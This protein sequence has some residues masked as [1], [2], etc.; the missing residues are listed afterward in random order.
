MAGEAASRLRTAPELATLLLELG[1]LIRAR[2]YYAPGDQR[3]AG[4]FERSLRAWRS[5]LGRRG[6]LEIEVVPEG[7]R[8]SGGRGVLSHPQLSELQQDLAER[9][10]HRLRFDPDLDGE[11][12]AAF[13]EVLATDAG[14]TAS[15]GGFATALYEHTPAG[16]LVNGVAPE[17][18]QPPA[19]PEPAAASPAAEFPDHLEEL[20]LE[21]PESLSISAELSSTD[22]LGEAAPSHDLDVLLR[23]LDEC[24]SASQYQ[25]LARRATLLAERAF[26]EGS[27]DDCY[28]VSVRLAAQAHG[29]ENPRLR[30]LADSFLRSL[31]QGVRLDDLV[32]RAA[33]ALD[34]GDLEASQVLLALGDAAVPAL[35]DAV[36]SLEN[37]AERERLTSVVVALVDQALPVVIERL[38]PGD[39][40][41]KVRAAA[42]IAG[43]LQHPDV[44]APLTSL[45]AAD[46]RGVREEAVRALVRV[47]SE[48]AVNA[49]A[50]ALDSEAPGLALAALHGL[51]S[52]GSA[53]AVPYL[54][55]AL[56]RAVE[57]RDVARAKEAIRALGRLGRP[58]AALA[59]VGLLERRVRLGGGW[60][61]ELKAVAVSA[62]AAVPGDEAVAALAQAAQARDAQLR[63]AAQTALDRRAQARARVGA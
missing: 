28:R 56:A 58:E 17:S 34:D 42:R 16:I 22:D 44:V 36:I 61:R 54:E 57:A 4:V 51:G 13:A 21:L 31:V 10:V 32:L 46:D 1:R 8:E 23:Q 48:G 60:L 47:G 40:P 20:D 50:K 38:R 59:L 27:P 26:D 15:R 37:T 39:A 62:L 43:E 5:D 6:A 33:R 45:L 35:L 2:R 9:G 12:F 29:K 19:A 49:L 18:L 14:R 25:D 53:R 11:V 52:T 24:T 3:L 63:R 41:A 30:D 7:F 55:R